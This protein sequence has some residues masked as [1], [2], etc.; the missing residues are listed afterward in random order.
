MLVRWDLD[1]ANP[2]QSQPAPRCRLGTSPSDFLPS[3]G[4]R[5]PKAA[6]KSAL[7]IFGLSRPLGLEYKTL[8]QGDKLTT[9]SP[10]DWWELLAFI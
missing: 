8:V 5:G 4:M 2:L 10:I 9:I 3:T 1:N 7:G 6:R